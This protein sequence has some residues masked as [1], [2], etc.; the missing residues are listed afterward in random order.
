MEMEIAESKR[1]ISL[2]RIRT[3]IAEKHDMNLS[4][5]SKEKQEAIHFYE[6][7]RQNMEKR[8]IQWHGW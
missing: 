2:G 1:K 5:W 7:F 8:D 4:L 3:E 6:K